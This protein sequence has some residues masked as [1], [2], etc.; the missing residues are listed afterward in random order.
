MERRDFLQTPWAAA[1]AVATE[2]LAPAQPGGPSATQ[3][4]IVRAGTDREA[5][6][7]TFLD[8][9]FN[10]LVSGKDT[11]GRFVIFDTLRPQ[12]TGPALH[13][14]TDCDEW[15]MVLDGTF[16]F[17]LGDREVQASAGDAL[18]APKGLPHAFIKVSEGTARML[19][20][21][22]PAGTMEEYFRTG[23]ARP[24]IT[25]DERRVLAEQHGM[26]ILGGPLSPA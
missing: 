22:Q 14:H 15:F 2:R 13:L 8:G 20:M 3:G 1:L 19:V 7:F 4:L 18:L 16:K 26:K 12:K 6:P 23:A 25:P 9:V 17:R 10:V 24:G 21:H 11:D 5:A